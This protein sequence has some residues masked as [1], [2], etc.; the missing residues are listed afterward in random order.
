MSGGETEFLTEEEDIGFTMT[1]PTPNKVRVCPE[2][3]PLKGDLVEEQMER[4][5]ASGEFRLASGEVDF[6][7]MTEVMRQLIAQQKEVVDKE[8]VRKKLNRLQNY[9]LEGAKAEAVM[10]RAAEIAGRHE[11]TPA[12]T[13]VSKTGLGKVSDLIS[14]KVKEK[15]EYLLCDMHDLEL[16]EKKK[17]EKEKNKLTRFGTIINKTVRFLDKYFPDEP[18]DEKFDGYVD[19]FNIMQKHGY[20]EYAHD[21]YEERMAELRLVQDIYDGAVRVKEIDGL[22]PLTD[23]ENVDIDGERD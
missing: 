16:E 6:V 12:T 4:R 10:A 5:V 21:Y 18:I 17:R 13:Q 2:D 15:V 14:D 23:D 20:A 8:D 9:V 3:F 7:A 19:F 11:A 1:S 22:D